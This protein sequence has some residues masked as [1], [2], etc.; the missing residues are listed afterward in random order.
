MAKMLEHQLWDYQSPMRQ[1]KRLP[2]DILDKIEGSRLTIE[3]MRDMDHREI[4][5]S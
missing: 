1:F 5:K 2:A 4:G 3:K